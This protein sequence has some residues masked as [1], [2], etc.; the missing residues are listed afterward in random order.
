MSLVEFTYDQATNMKGLR[1]LT[2]CFDISS[3]ANAFLCAARSYDRT[4]SLILQFAAMYNL[5]NFLLPS[6]QVR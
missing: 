6:R 3:C 4:T 1:A 2:S 5:R